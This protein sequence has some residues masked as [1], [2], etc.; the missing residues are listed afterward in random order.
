MNM[1]RVTLITLAVTDLA[2]AR[3]YYEGL[4]WQPEEALE[5]VAFYTMDGMK[6]GL[7]TL[8]GLKRETGRDDLATGATT[9]AQNFSTEAE[10]DDMF[11]RAIAAGAKPLAPPSKMEWGGYSSY[12]EDPD[13]HIWEFAMNPFWTVDPQGRL[14]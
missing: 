8:E 9:L 7:F 13:G 4:G 11:A 5:Q 12:V 14:A 6:F 10:V 3:A 1:N 2:R